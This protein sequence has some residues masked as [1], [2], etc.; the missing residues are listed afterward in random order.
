MNWQLL[1]APLGIALLVVL[2][3]SLGALKQAKLASPEAARQRF[4]QDFPARRIESAVV[5][6]DRR[7]ALLALADGS[8]GVVFAVGD[9][10]ATRLLAAGTA[11]RAR[12]DANRL[13]LMS[14]DGTT[15]PIA[16]RLQTD[17][18]TDA[19]SN[20]LRTVLGAA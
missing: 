12:R 1:L 16:V 17:A 4:A 19:W 6:A 3:I 18:D 8:I 9:R 15:A 7:S 11:W 2:S 20:R 10:L 14:R 5:S 13:V